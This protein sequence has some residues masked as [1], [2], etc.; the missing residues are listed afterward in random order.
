MDA[1]GPGA[2]VRF[3]SANPADAGNLRV[4][5]DGA[6]TPVIDLPLDD[7]LG[8]K[9]ALAPPPVGGVRGKGWNSYLP[10]PY[11]KH[12]KVTT[13]APDYYYLINY[14]SYAEG[15]AVETYSD[16]VAGRHAGDLRRAAEA[17][18]APRGA[19]RPSSAPWCWAPA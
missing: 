5:L 8:G 15:T 10:I 13:T 12:C 9:T 19:A 6:T 3:W 2:I 7:Y 11:A 1:A 18:A 16:A 17:L 14:R 4:Y